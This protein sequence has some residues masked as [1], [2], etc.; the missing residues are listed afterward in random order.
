M[1]LLLTTI[2]HPSNTSFLIDGGFARISNNVVTVLAYDV[3]CVSEIE[4]DKAQQMLAEAKKLTGESAQVIC[5][6]AA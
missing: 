6:S 3:T 4:M 2:R 1:I 5:A